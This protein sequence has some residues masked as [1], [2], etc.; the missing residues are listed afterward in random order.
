[1]SNQNR[2]ISKVRFIEKSQSLLLETPDGNSYFLNLNLAL[3]QAGIP[4]TKKNG[5]SISAAQIKKMKADSHRKYMAAVE[6]NNQSEART[7]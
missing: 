4:Y 2:N 1:M 5:E 3:F 7:A 6:R